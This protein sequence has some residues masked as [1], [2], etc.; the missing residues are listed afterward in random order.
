MK[1]IP[2]QKPIWL[3]LHSADGESD[4]ELLIPLIHTLPHLCLIRNSLLVSFLSL[5]S[6][7]QASS[8]EC[9]PEEQHRDTAITDRS[10]SVRVR[11]VRGEY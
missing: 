2:N 7:I 1:G 8:R 6:M 5:L 9:D 10:M 11:G 4:A 3:W